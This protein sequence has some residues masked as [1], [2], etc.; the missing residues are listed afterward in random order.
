M[1]KLLRTSI[2]NKNILQN[3][4]IHISAINQIKE[5]LVNEDKSK[6]LITIEGHYLD[7]EQLT[8]TKVLKFAEDDQKT[9]CS[10]CKLEKQDIFVQYT[11]TLVIRQ[12]LRE[13]GTVLPKK[14]TGL[15]K[16]QHKKLHV[17]VKQANMAGL[18]LNLQPPLLNG[19]RPS[20]VQE[21]RFQHLKW[22]NAFDDYEILKKEKKYL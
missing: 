6:K 5:I 13:D 10:F 9:T 17:L 16:K 7:S 8:N 11:D 4:P 22:N 2:F 19:T 14:I 21:N 15:C 1:L 20:V 3:R 12:F 18:I